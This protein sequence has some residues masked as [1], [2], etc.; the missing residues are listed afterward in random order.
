MPGLT[1]AIDDKHSA[2]VTVAVVLQDKVISP[3]ITD[4][5]WRHQSLDE[6]IRS[7]H[8]QIRYLVE[9]DGHD[10]DERRIN[11]NDGSDDDNKDDIQA[12]QQR[13]DCLNKEKQET[14]VLFKAL[15]KFRG[16]FC[17]VALYL[18]ST[19]LL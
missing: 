12:V 11:E 6:N 14:E 9:R 1:S 8:D 13:L 5:E 16:S 7:A 2:F 17:L 15:R 4:I 19:Y 3:I 10:G 18:A